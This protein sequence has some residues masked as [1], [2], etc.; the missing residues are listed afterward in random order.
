M[1]SCGDVYDICGFMC[2]LECFELVLG[3][4]WGHGSLGAMIIVMR[5]QMSDCRTYVAI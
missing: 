3:W 2:L 1:L 4:G 5:C